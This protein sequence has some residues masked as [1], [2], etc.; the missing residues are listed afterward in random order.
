MNGVLILLPIILGLGVGFAGM[1]I[2][3]AKRGQF[4]D[5]DDPPKRMLKDD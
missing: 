5:L 1:F 4:D 3:A 2:Y